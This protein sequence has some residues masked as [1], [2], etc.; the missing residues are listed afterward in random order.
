MARVST[1][2]N[3]HARHQATLYIYQ[4]VQHK[5]WGVTDRWATNQQLSYNRMQ[6]SAPSSIDT[7]NPRSSMAHVLGRKSYGVEGYGAYIEDKQKCFST[8]DSTTITFF[9]KRI[10]S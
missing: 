4:H 2:L 1:P 9:L 7:E 10:I 5:G 3:E 8:G 6:I